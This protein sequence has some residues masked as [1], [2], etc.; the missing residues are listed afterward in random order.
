MGVILYEFLFGYPPFNSDTA[1]KIFENILH[2]DIQWHEEVM[3]IS[4]SARNLMESFLER[5]WRKRLGSLGIVDIKSHSWFK[6]VIWNGLNLQEAQFVPRTR[7][8]TDTEYFDDRGAKDQN[9]E[10]EDA[11]DTNSNDLKN[12]KIPQMIIMDDISHLRESTVYKKKDD[13]F[14]GFMYRNLPLLE[15]ANQKL[16]QKLKSDFI[17]ADKLKSRNLLKL[18]QNASSDFSSHIRKSSSLSRSGIESESESSELNLATSTRRSRQSSVPLGTRKR[19]DT[20]KGSS[21]SPYATFAMTKSS[22]IQRSPKL[23]SETKPLDILIAVI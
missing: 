17:G 22:Q 8:A 16:V 15:K 2:Q 19:S 1:Q 10:D 5:D 11:E 4:A 7:D 6:E 13:D 12:R 3:D 20:G 23:E 21:M 14:G 9:F 18:R